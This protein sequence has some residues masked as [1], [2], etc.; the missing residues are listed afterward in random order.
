MSANVDELEESEDDFDALE[1][2][3]NKINRERDWTVEARV[4]NASAQLKVDTGSEANLLP[5]GH[6]KKMHPKTTSIEQCGLEF[7]RWGSD[8]TLRCYQGR[9]RN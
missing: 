2:W 9:S 4:N 5:F 3:V 6:Y 8:Y 1:I 7:V